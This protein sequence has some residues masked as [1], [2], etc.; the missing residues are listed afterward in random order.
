MPTIS[1]V[2]PVY[3]VEA[4]LHRCVDSIL[5][6]TYRDF[7]LILVDDGS[8]D[9]CGG[10]CD[11]YARQDS[12]V[13]V[14]HQANGGL[15]AARNAGIDWV[16][17]ESDSQWFTFVDSDDWL[18]SETLERLLRAAEEHQTKVSVCGYAETAGEDPVVMPESLASAAVDPRW[19]YRSRFINATVAWGK[20]Y[21]RELF[22]TVRYPVGKIHEDEFVTYRLLMESG[23]IAV[24]EAPLYAYFV[25]L[26]GI[27]KKGWSPRKL[28]AWEAYEQQLAFFEERQDTEMVKFR[29][30]GYLENAVVNLQQ[31]QESNANG[32]YDKEVKNIE[33]RIRQVIRRAWKKDVLSFR[34][35]F[36]LLFRFYPL[37]TRG[38]R[39]WLER[40]LKK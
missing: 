10:I 14:I 18:H 4:Y 32:Q 38:Y 23:G 34:E 1:V 37:L 35:D 7:E 39:F 5:Q 3:K 25:N 28:H 19:F 33:N 11:A 29:Y 17:A 15:S 40:I 26:A 21:R 30:R 16:F 24:L 13:H 8:P 36:E 20:L 9:N 27:T 12:R 31:A 2:V 6:Q 22:E